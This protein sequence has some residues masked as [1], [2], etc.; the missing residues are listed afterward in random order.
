MDGWVLKLDR[1]GRPLGAWSLSDGPIA[2]HLV[3]P[4]TGRVAAVLTLAGPPAVA[5]TAGV[6]PEPGPTAEEQETD[7]QPSDLQPEPAT[8]IAAPAEEATEGPTVRG[9]DEWP[10]T[11]ELPEADDVLLPEA[12]P[13]AEAGSGGG[14]DDD[15]S[16][17]APEDTED[18]EEG[19]LQP[20]D[21]IAIAHRGVTT[22]PPAPHAAPVR[23]RVQPWKP[24]RSGPGEER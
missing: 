21:M 4:D 20:D 5:D 6:P 13:P 12:S 8:T 11:P 7:L 17:P 10:P 1:D 9:Y 22:E 24:P 18:P 19:E 14:A 23:S 2:V 3:D 16:L 15:L